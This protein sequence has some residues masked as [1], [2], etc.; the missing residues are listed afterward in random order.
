MAAMA[1]ATQNKIL[2]P[3]APRLRSTQVDKC[4]D[5]FLVKHQPTGLS[6]LKS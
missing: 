6:L 3:I 1:A 5:T 4:I 2:D